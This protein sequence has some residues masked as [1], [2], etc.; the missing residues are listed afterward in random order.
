MSRIY[1]AK[2]KFTGSD[3]GHVYW[4]LI[5]RVFNIF[6]QN[7]VS[8]KNPTF[9]ISSPK[10]CRTGCIFNKFPKKI[11][12]FFKYQSLRVFKKTSWTLRKKLNVFGFENNESVATN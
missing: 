10:K 7:Y 12:V 2:T 4:K 6:C 9:A 3:S 11:S 1:Q 8:Q 5:S